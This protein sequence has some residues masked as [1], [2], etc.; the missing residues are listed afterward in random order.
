[1]FESAVL[2]GQRP[3]YLGCGWTIRSSME[4]FICIDR[5]LTQAADYNFSQVPPVTR[6]PLVEHMG[7]VRQ[8]ST[9]ISRY[10]FVSVGWAQWQIVRKVWFIT[11]IA[12]GIFVLGDVTKCDI[13]ARSWTP[14]HC[15]PCNSMTRPLTRGNRSFHRGTV[16]FTIS[17]AIE[18]PISQNFIPSLSFCSNPTKSHALQSFIPSYKTIFLLLIYLSHLS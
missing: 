8:K 5:H 13:I 17:F 6:T 1:M 7:P 10:P 18:C 12:P 4:P 11:R 15:K 3:H 14:M 2:I 16:W 9:R